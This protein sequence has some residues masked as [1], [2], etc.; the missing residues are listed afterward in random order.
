MSEGRTAAAGLVVPDLDGM[1]GALLLGL[2][3]DRLLA[4]VP[5]ELDGDSALARAGSV[6]IARERLA[7][8]ALAAVQDI[9]CREL[10]ALA[11]AGSTRSWLR[12]QLSGDQG[13]LGL[14]RRLADRPLVTGALA[15]GQISLRA[16]GQLGG[17]L[18]QVPTQVAEPALLAVLTDGIAGLLGA[19]TGS[20]LLPEVPPSP[21]A[22]AVRAELATVT[23]AVCAATTAT[24]A[25]RLEPAVL[26]LARH[27]SPGLLGPSLGYLLDALLP[28]GIDLPDPD[29]Y[30]LHLQP[31]LD[32]D[33][34]LRGHLDPETGTLLAREIDRRHKASTGQPADQAEETETEDADADADAD[35][36][37]DEPDDEND[38]GPVEEIAN[39]AS[40]ETDDE[41]D[42][43]EPATTDE[44][45]IALTAET[46][47]DSAPWLLP[48]PD[49]HASTSDRPVPAG[50]RRHDALT[51]LLRDTASL[52]AGSGRP[53]PAAMLIT[54]SIEALEGRL[55]ALPGTLST[56]GQPISL[57]AATLRRL[58]CNSEL[59]AVLLDAAG[60]PVGA[61]STR[62]SA[63]RKERAALRIQWGPWCAIDGCPNTDTVPHHVPPWWLTRTTR[64]R[65]LIPICDH[66][67]RAVHEQHRTLRLKDGRHI[68]EYGWTKIPAGR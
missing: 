60:H 58:G 61:S 45:V 48:T 20:H 32:G 26:L 36:V 41:P 23:A 2:A 15:D 22:L 47:E 25:A 51:Q 17:A 13:Q 55:G 27:L 38:D 8:V 37:G 59:T 50:Q 40:D 3:V 5:V 35:A 21:H 67:H 12:T 6:L 65:D 52:T 49:P 11:C 64:L 56:T 7:A 28:D 9:D 10:Y 1:P 31:L 46:A 39:P 44:P 62:R 68:D 53:A 18:D 54:S 66:D 34:D 43:V 33:W 24:P 16:A 4:E 19:V 57:P 30:Y 42:G 14:A 29:E 63:N